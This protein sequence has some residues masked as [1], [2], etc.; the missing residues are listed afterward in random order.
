MSMPARTLKPSSRNPW[1]SPPA[2]QKTSTTAP[3]PR[4]GAASWSGAGDCWVGKFTGSSRSPSRLPS[5]GRRDWHGRSHG[6]FT[7]TPAD[8]W[9]ASATN[10]TPSP[11]TATVQEGSEQPYLLP[12]ELRGGGEAPEGDWQTQLADWAREK[13]RDGA[14]GVLT[15]AALTK[16]ALTEAALTKA[17]LTK[18]C[19]PLRPR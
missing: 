11:K 17:A 12:P 4:F 18:A 16:A 14:K 1:L 19:R 15:E 9:R 8:G 10:P 5:D 3:R 13:L 6:S 7:S 2:P